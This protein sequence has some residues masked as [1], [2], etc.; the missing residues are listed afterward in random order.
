MARTHP[1]VDAYLLAFPPLLAIIAFAV[2]FPVFQGVKVVK[3]LLL[4]RSVAAV[5]PDPTEN[6]SP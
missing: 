5:N 4:G 2:M 1:L 6:P 3:R